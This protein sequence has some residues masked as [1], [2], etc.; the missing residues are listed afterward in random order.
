MLCIYTSSLLLSIQFSICNAPPASFM[1][2]LTSEFL[3]LFHFKIVNF[4]QFS[5]SRGKCD[6]SYDYLYIY[7][8]IYIYIYVYI[9]IYIYIYISK[10]VCV[11]IYQSIPYLYGNHKY[12][13]TK[14]MTS[15]YSRI[16]IFPLVY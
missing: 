6:T 14:V 15:Y 2:R 3:V 13:I 10:F 4:F 7:I 8:Y 11:L 9:Y 12:I 5:L 1:L 16:N